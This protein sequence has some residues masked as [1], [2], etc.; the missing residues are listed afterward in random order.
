MKRAL[1]LTAYNRPE[2]LR[3]SLTSWESV[4]DLDGWRFFATVEPSPK[5]DEICEIL[6]DFESRVGVGMEVRIN[7]E[8]YG[9]SRHPWVIFESLF[10]DGFDFVVRTEDDIVVSS[11]ILRFF[12]WSSETFERDPEIA[13]VNAFNTMTSDPSQPGI[14]QTSTQFSPLVWGTWR[15]RWERVIGPTWDH[16]YST[17]NGHPGNQ[18]GWDWNLNTRIL[19]KLG[20]KCA[21]PSAP[22]SD[23]IGVVGTHGTRENFFRN[24]HF[25]QHW[26]ATEFRKAD[27][28]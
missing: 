16:D 8:R 15:D 25:S 1:F 2:Y 19:P 6:H 4:S 22:R 24:P 9:V 23:H 27:I 10:T 14:V 3:D 26:E 28:T 18:S 7:P 5:Q 13:T 17:Y 21:V 20:L 11:D 12:R